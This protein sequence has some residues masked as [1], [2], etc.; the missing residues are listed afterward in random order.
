MKLVAVFVF[1]LI[2]SVAFEVLER[3]ERC[4][5][6]YVWSISF[7]S[8]FFLCPCVHYARSSND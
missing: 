4:K 1:V 5:V 6:R 3:L 2:N 7:L 8:V